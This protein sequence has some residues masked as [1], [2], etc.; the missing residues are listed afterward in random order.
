M[1]HPHVPDAAR[2]VLAGRGL[3]RARRRE[4]EREKTEDTRVSVWELGVPPPSSF[5]SLTVLSTLVCGR[6][7]RVRVPAPGG[8]A[9]LQRQSPVCV[10]CPVT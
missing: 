10:L 2:A 4:R 6:C 1:P 8:R 7:A 9:R 5:V 3:A